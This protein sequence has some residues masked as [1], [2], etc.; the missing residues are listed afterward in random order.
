MKDAGRLTSQVIHD[1]Y[2]YGIDA[3]FL[4]GVEQL[5]QYFEWHLDVA[6]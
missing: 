3:I 2:H 4:E 6:C 5:F 1:R